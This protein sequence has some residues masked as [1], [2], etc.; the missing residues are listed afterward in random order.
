MT[1]EETALIKSQTIF[2]FTSAL[3]GLFLNVF[4]FKIGSL[5]SVVKFHL[6]SLVF[7][8]F[9]YL[10][11]GWL[12][13]KWNSKVFMKL[14]FF[15][16]LLLYLLLFTL[17]E[18][19]IYFLF[20]LGLFHGTGH[21][22]FWSANNLTQYV[23]TYEKTRLHF[24]GRQSFWLSIASAMGPIIGGLIITSSRVVTFTN[25]IGYTT[26]FLV[27][28]F[29]MF[30]LFLLADKIPSFTGIRFSLKD[31]LTH[32]R[33]RNWKLVLVQQGLAGLWDVSFVGIS[34]ILI[35]LIV[36]EEIILGAVNT[37]SAFIFALA[38]LLAA[39]QLQKTKQYF[40]LGTVLAP[41]GLLLFAWQQNWLGIL[42]LLFINNIF[43]PYLNIP[44]SSLIYDEIDKVKKRWQEKYHFLIERDLVLGIARISTYLVLLYFFVGAPDQVS[45]ARSWIYLIPVFPF[46]MG[47]SF[48]FLHRYA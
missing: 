27:V 34:G 9:W 29:L 30:Y 19:S 14:G 36:K 16:F 2:F 33:S 12:F 45:I 47:I 43:L 24:F 4:L 22:N 17:K 11:S 42:C 28:A 44:A 21:G 37:T 18:K 5:E 6:T 25:N 41:I 15:S 31:I 26:L 35:Y 7:L 3:A 10:L 1:K 46:L 8:L 48:L 23:S 20:L 40:I 38:S 13:K 32:R 39:K